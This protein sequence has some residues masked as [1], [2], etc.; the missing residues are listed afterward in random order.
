MSEQA[1][2]ETNAVEPQPISS[3]TPNEQAVSS[4]VDANPAGSNENEK[5]ATNSVN[6]TLRKKKVGAKSV[7]KKADP[8]KKSSSK[9][10]ATSKSKAKNSH[11][12]FFEMITEAIKKLNERSGSSRQAILKFIV[13]NFHVEEKSGNQHIKIGLKNAV[14]AGSLKQV[15]GVGASGSFKLGD[16]FKSKSVK[17]NLTT[18]VAAAKRKPSTTKKPIK[19]KKV[20]AAAAAKKITAVAP[21]K[22]TN[23]PKKNLKKSNSKTVAK[24]VTKNKTVTKAAA[25]SKTKSAPTINRKAKTVQSGKKGFARGSRK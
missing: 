10:T 20:T 2:T 15:K 18:T 24:K 3:S 7:V 12:P 21:K 11:P 16:A 6:V 14:K 25:K 1:K 8:V 22:I 4:A 9:S 23:K 17:K 19:I 13:S 5:P